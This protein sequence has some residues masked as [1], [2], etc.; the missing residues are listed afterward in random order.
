MTTRM[1]KRRFFEQ[2]F[3][4]ELIS[5]C[6]IC[7]LDKIASQGCT[8]FFMK[9]YI[10]FNDSILIILPISALVAELRL[11]ALIFLA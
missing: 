6:F 7:K 5:N 8:T 3:F 11:H 2:C 10:N 9:S 4:Q 1:L